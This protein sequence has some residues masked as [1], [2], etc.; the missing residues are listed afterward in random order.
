MKSL[1]ALQAAS[2]LSLLNL[3]DVGPKQQDPSTGTPTSPTWKI[4]VLDEVSK[5]ILA[6][7]L[8]VQDLRDVGVTLHVSVHP[9]NPFFQLLIFPTVTR[10]LHTPRPPLPDVPAVYLVSPTIVNIRRIAQVASAALLETRN[11]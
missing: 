11:N 7:V 4:L 3:N 6:T 8:R 9:P 5:D 10:Q 1:Q 2:V